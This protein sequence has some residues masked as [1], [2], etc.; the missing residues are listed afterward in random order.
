MIVPVIAIDGPS[1]SGKG[2][3]IQ[4]LTERLDPRAFR[5][6]P[7][8]PPSELEQ[9]FRKAINVAGRNNKAVAPVRDQ[10]TSSDTV[11]DNYR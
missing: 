4:R 6:H 2:T 7:G 9:R 3:I 5:V 8:A 11:A 1:A 10:I